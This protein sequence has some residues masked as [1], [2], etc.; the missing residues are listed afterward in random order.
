MHCEFPREGMGRIRVLLFSLP[1]SEVKGD[2][3]PVSPSSFDPN[4]VVIFSQNQF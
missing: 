3:I 4:D 1:D 2:S